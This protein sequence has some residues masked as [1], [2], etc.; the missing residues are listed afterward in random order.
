MLVVKS[1]NDLKLQIG[2]KEDKKKGG[3]M[4]FLWD[5]KVDFGVQLRFA[6]KDNKEEFSDFIRK[7]VWVCLF[8]I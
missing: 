5:T 6:K 8:Y 3:M 4:S 7:M 2:I 1:I